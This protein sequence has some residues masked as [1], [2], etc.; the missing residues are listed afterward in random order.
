MPP[1]PDVPGIRHADHA[2]PTGVTLHVAEAGDPAAPAVLAV[3]GWPQHWWMWRQ[4]CPGGCPRPTASLCPDLRGLGW[5]G[6][7]DDGDF[8]KERFAD[9]M[10]ALLDVLGLERVGVLGHDWG[11]GPAGCSRCARPSGSSA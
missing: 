2:I 3:H 5:S 1:M 6:Q 9:D 10:L 8:A 4:R 11:G 7:P